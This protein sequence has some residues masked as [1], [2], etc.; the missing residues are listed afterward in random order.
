MASSSILRAVATLLNALAD[1]SAQP[2]CLHCQNVAPCTPTPS[3]AADVAAALATSL[4][5][6]PTS[7]SL[8]G[9]VPTQ[10]PPRTLSP[11][12]STELTTATPAVMRAVRSCFTQTWRPSQQTPS[13]STR[14]T[15]TWRRPRRAATPRAPTPL[16]SDTHGHGQSGQGP[17]G[18]VPAEPPERPA[19][20]PERMLKQT[21]E[22]IECVATTTAGSQTVAT[23]PC[24]PA[25]CTRPASPSRQISSPG[26]A[27]H[28]PSDE[29]N[30]EVPSDETDVKS[31]RTRFLLAAENKE[32]VT[33]RSQRALKK[34]K[35]KLNDLKTNPPDSSHAKPKKQPAQSSTRGRVQRAVYQPLR[36]PPGASLPPRP[37]WLAEEVAVEKVQR[38]VRAE[39]Q[40][41]DQL[42]REQRQARA[43]CCARNAPPRAH[44]QPVASASDARSK[45]KRRRPKKKKRQQEELSPTDSEYEVSNNVCWES[46]PVDDM[47]PDFANRR[48]VN[49]C[50]YYVKRCQAYNANGQGV[51]AFVDQLTRASPASQD[52]AV[53]N[54]LFRHGAAARAA[55]SALGVGQLVFSENIEERNHQE[56]PSYP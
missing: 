24:T 40:A 47:F 26:L 41:R 11:L 7:L 50:R 44:V 48:E 14:F 16:E 13:T 39:E 25:E 15:Q 42:E 9:S 35:R 22:D 28:S 37:P 3:R 5:S 43:V 30:V 52:D 31:P 19:D 45:Q 10:S 2:A 23:P 27:E 46:R 12:A 49:Y 56:A 4:S 21:F 6:S 1:V 33:R 38:M 53:E 55:W 20:D 32:V 18:V 51:L 54:L 34:H 36:P 17:E 8:T 29:S